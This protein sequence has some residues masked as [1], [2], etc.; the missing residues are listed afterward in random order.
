MIMVNAPLQA[1]E[2]IEMTNEEMG[3]VLWQ[4]CQLSF[5]DNFGCFRSK[6]LSTK[7]GLQDFWSKSTTVTLL[8]IFGLKFSEKKKY[9][10]PT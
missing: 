6:V 5:P 8:V 4:F 10:G 3:A 7:F 9:F 1:L 2:S